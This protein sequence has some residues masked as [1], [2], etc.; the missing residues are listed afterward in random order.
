[1]EWPRKPTIVEWAFLGRSTCLGPLPLASWVVG[2][3]PLSPD[4]L[5]FVVSSYVELRRACVG[6]GAL[7]RGEEAAARAFVECL[8]AFCE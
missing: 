3:L 6:V 2:A 4:R 7:G 8:R 1:M 5:R